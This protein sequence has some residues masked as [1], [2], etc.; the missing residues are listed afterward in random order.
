MKE[1]DMQNIRVKACGRDATGKL[2]YISFHDLSDRAKAA[3]LPF[4]LGL[5]Q[6]A[7]DLLINV[8]NPLGDC[9]MV[10]RRTQRLLDT[11]SDTVRLGGLELD[12]RYRFEVKLPDRRETDRYELV[13]LY[14]RV[15]FGTEWMLVDRAGVHECV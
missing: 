8:E 6:S 12:R 2:R 14:T 13:A 11:L 10:E 5:A 9:E 15:A 4:G 7:H 1:R 3:G